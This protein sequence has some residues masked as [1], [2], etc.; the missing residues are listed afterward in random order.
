[1]T[2]PLRWRL[3][4][5]TVLSIWGAGVVIIGFVQLGSTLRWWNCPPMQSSV[6]DSFFVLTDGTACLF[7]GWACWKGMFRLA[8][9][10]VAVAVAVYLVGFFYYFSRF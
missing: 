2:Q 4:P 7:A 5:T 1:M 3:I 8:M 9:T 6:S 10:A